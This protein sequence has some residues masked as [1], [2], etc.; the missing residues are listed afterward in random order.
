MSSCKKNFN[1]KS[2]LLVLFCF[3]SCN[4]Q[5]H[6]LKNSLNEPSQQQINAVF[7]SALP[8]IQPSLSQSPSRIPSIDID[9][10]SSQDFGLG[11]ASVTFLLKIT[12]FNLPN[13]SSKCP[14][15][16]QSFYVETR[17]GL[18][19]QE[20][21]DFQLAQLKD[22]PLSFIYKGLPEGQKVDIGVGPIYLREMRL[23][24][25]IN[26][27]AIASQ[28][29]TTVH[30]NIPARIWPESNKYTK[31]IGTYPAFT[32]PISSAPVDG[33]IVEGGK[34]FYKSL[35]FK[36][37]STLN[38]SEWQ[39]INIDPFPKYKA[40]LHPLKPNYPVPNISIGNTGKV[41]I[42]L[43]APKR[44]G[45]Y[46]SNWMF[47]DPSKDIFHFSE[48]ITGMDIKVE[49]TPE[50]IPRVDGDAY[51][52][53]DSLIIGKNDKEKYMSINYIVLQGSYIDVYYQLKNTGN[54]TWE[55]RKLKLVKDNITKQ[56]LLTPNLEIL[57]IPRTEPGQVAKIG[58]VTYHISSKKSYF[59]AWKMVDAQGFNSFEGDPEAISQVLIA[60]GPTFCG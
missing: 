14:P 17:G 30:I 25:R 16:Y 1:S 13:P 46:Q 38:W 44:P 9:E 43:L 28:R 4:T 53:E 33:D 49:G 18:T 10:G 51:N 8:S 58:P 55:Q 2:F 29:G 56:E 21:D 7:Q 32:I 20:I 26:T 31:T 52:I 40:S 22:K 24:N 60:P 27:I 35:T 37:T 47:K 12:D 48:F 3:C 15:E 39:F 36:N 45:R 19:K 41:V 11:E 42:S 6:L 34:V 5:N 23:I 50:F 57:E 54:V 59:S